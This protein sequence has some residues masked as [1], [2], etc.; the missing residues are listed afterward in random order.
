MV[1]ISSTV[2]LQ[3][4]KM[5]VK[6]FSITTKVRGEKRGSNGKEMTKS[7]LSTSLIDW[8]ESVHS[9]ENL[10]LAPESWFQ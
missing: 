1:G 2:V 5:A 4:K 7:S 10:F 3:I 8:R 6:D 9:E